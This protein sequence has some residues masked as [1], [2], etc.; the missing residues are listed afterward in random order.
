[1]GIAKA[2]AGAAGQAQDLSGTTGAAGLTPVGTGERQ[3]LL[4]PDL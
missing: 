2:S 4:Q 1:M 3:R